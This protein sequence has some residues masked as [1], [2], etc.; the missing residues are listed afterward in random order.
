MFRDSADSGSSDRVF[1]IVPRSVLAMLCHYANAD[2]RGNHRFYDLKDRLLR[3]YAAFDGHDMQ[4]ITKECWGDKRDEYGEW[5]RCGKS[6]RRCGGTGVW[7]QRWV[8]LQRWRWGKYTF[9]I[10][11]GDTRIKPDS[12]Q[13]VGRIEH[14][15]YGRAS[16]EAELWLYAVTLQWSTLW[17][18][19]SSGYYCQ[20]GFWP[21][22]VMQ[23]LAT[24]LRLLFHRKR[25]WCGK[26]FWTWGSG[27]QICRQC[28]RPRTRNTANDLSL[29]DD[30]PF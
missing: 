14:P 19:L 11:D 13:I 26:W 21:M 15:D 2:A 6:C 30:V 24:K 27:W 1:S 12:V 8:R 7:D 28:R 18:Q 25:C 17:K 3:Q 5:T 9:H 4:V 23:K 20:P 16:R 29:E 22:C 10:P